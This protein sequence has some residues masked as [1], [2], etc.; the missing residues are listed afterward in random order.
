MKKLAIRVAVAG[1]ILIIAGILL[2]ALFL[3]G[4]IKKGVETVE[5]G[6]AHV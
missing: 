1:L 5:I 3:D 4:L 2:F 6:R